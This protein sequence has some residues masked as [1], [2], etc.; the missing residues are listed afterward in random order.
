MDAPTRLAERPRYSRRTYPTGHRVAANPCGA[1]TWNL[2]GVPTRHHKSGQNE[3]PMARPICPLHAPCT[4]APNAPTAH[5]PDVLPPGADRCMCPRLVLHPKIG[6][7]AR[8][9]MARVGPHIGRQPC[10][11]SKLQPQIIQGFIRWVRPIGQ[12]EFH[13]CGVLARPPLRIQASQ[14]VFDASVTDRVT[15]RQCVFV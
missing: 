6:R 2:W 5:T 3:R 9:S 1:T 7:R 8:Q 11:G 10:A 15:R 12:H 4:N 13:G 14:M